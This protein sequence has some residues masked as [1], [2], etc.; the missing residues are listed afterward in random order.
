MKHKVKAM[1]KAVNSH[2]GELKMTYR[3]L[4]LPLDEENNTFLNLKK[5]QEEQTKPLGK[6]LSQ[7]LLQAN[8]SEGM[9][10]LKSYY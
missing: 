5:L 9:L 8:N 2:F 1:N 6:S 4:D 7:P 10:R 3:K